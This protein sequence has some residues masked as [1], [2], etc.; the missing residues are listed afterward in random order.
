ML[1]DPTDPPP[2]LL[3]GSG[4][5]DLEG[6]RARSVCRKRWN[7]SQLLP[8]VAVGDRFSLDHP[9]T[10]FALATGRQPDPVHQLSHDPLVEADVR[11][12]R[13]LPVQAE[14]PEGAGLRQPATQPGMMQEHRL[15]NVG[16]HLTSRRSIS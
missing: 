6:I 7:A 13:L 8:A 4:G 5:G 15:L 14:Q 12:S 16:D 1:G 3:A 9:G 11:A 10:G 2:F